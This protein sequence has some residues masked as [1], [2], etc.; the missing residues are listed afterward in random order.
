MRLL[1]CLVLAVSGVVVAGSVDGRALQSD[2]PRDGYWRCFTAP[3]QN[4]IYFTGVWEERALA[5][6]VH[7]GFVKFLADKYGYKGR[8]SCATS[9]KGPSDLAKAK[10][11]S[12]ALQ[13]HYQKSGSKVI[14]T[15]WTHQTSAA[16]GTL[17]ASGATAAVAAPAPAQGQPTHWSACKIDRY[18]PGATVNGPF[19]TYISDVFPVDPKVNPALV[20]AYGQFISA[21]YGPERDNPLCNVRTSE[22]GVREMHKTWIGEA[23]KNGK[24]ILTGWKFPEK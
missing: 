17:P 6:D 14:D 7:A 3:D 1:G 16:A 4:P 23:N 9:T 2:R 12:L 5:T 8:V 18:A 21:K 15:G 13:Q 10:A 24:A 11:D 19:N 22:A 20:K